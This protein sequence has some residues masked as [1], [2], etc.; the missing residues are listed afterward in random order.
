MAKYQL[1]LFWLQ[2]FLGFP[3]SARIALAD[4]FPPLPLPSETSHTLANLQ[5]LVKQKAMILRQEIVQL[6]KPTL[7]SCSFPHTYG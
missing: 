5:S 2:A 3:S 6:D 7:Q 1:P 4:P